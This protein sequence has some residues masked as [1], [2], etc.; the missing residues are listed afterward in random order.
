MTGIIGLALIL[1]GVRSLYRYKRK[2]KSL[3]RS[4]IWADSVVD[5]LQSEIK[6]GHPIG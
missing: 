4:R 5:W 3:K 2:Q 6:K 1:F